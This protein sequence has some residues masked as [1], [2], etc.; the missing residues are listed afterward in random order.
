M[1]LSKNSMAGL[2][3][4]LLMIGG[5]AGYFISFVIKN[6]QN[7]EAFMDVV[8]LTSKMQ[9]LNTYLYQQSFENRQEILKANWPEAEKDFKDLYLKHK[10]SQVA[11]CFLFFK[12]PLIWQSVENFT[13][14]LK[15][16]ENAWNRFNNED[17]TLGQGK[18]IDFFA[19]V[20]V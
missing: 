11:F 17:E 14:A 13:L 8:H 12:S 20:N 4:I 15:V 3:S 19:Q 10:N 18:S 7:T 9:A 2:V 16:F 5:A 6:K 1:Q